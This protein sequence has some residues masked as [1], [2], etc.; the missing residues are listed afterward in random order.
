MDTLPWTLLQLSLIFSQRSGVGA[1]RFIPSFANLA[2]L[3]SRYK[4]IVI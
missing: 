3:E 1:A 4:T 2:A